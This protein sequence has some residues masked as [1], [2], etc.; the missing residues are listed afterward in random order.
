MEPLKGK[1]VGGSD[2]VAVCTKQQRI[3][4][5]AQQ[6]PKMVL[7]TL[8]HHLDLTWLREAY[9]RTRKDGAVSVDG[10]TSQAYA[11]NLDENLGSLLDRAKSG[12]YRA[13]TVRRVHIPKG[14]SKTGTRPI[15]IPTVV[16]PRRV[17]HA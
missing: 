1:T 9:A 8:A 14:G 12:R 11:A 2:P 10:Q 13:P 15:G 3:A 6:S 17:Q 7:T 16:H 5:L 4:E